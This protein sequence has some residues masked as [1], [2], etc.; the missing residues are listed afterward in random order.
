MTK[1]EKLTRR[2]VEC[3]Y[4]S[5]LYNAHYYEWDEAALSF[6]NTI[7]GEL[8]SE[9]ETK[10]RFAL[11]HYGEGASAKLVRVWLGAPFPSEALALAA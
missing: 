1:L 5:W 9:I 11:E 3:A 4:R 2:Q 8:A 7:T 10:Q 6:R